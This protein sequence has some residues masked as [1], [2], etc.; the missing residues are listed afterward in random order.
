MFRYYSI[1]EQSPWEM[2]LDTPEALEA[3]IAKQCQMVSV[4]AISDDFNDDSDPDK[5]TY[6]GGL[7]FDIDY[8]KRL[9]KSIEA[10]H[11]LIGKLEGQGVDRQDILVWASGK[12]GFHIVVPSK[13][14]SSGRAIRYLPYIYKEMALELFVDGVDMVVYSGKKGRL[15]RQEN[16]QRADNGKFKVGLLPEEVNNLTVEEYTRLTDKARNIEQLTPCKE[17]TKLSVLFELC[18]KRVIFKQKQQKQDI[19]SEVSDELLSQFSETL[20]GCIQKLVEE[21][22]NEGTSN[23]NQAAMQF[24]IFV[25]RSKMH[26]NFWQPIVEQMAKNVTSGTYKTERNRVEHLIGMIRYAATSSSRKFSRGALFSVISPCGGCPICQTAEGEDI[27]DVD[28]DNLAGITERAD[29][30]Y[31]AT[32]DGARRITT[33]TIKPE[34][35]YTTKAQDTELTRR[36][37]IEAGIMVGG[38]EIASAKIEESAWD[39]KGSLIKELRGIKNLAFLGGDQEVQRLKHYLFTKE[40]DM[41]EI[42]Q[43]F[44]AG[45]HRHPVGKLSTLVYVEPGFSVTAQKERDTHYVDGR[46][47]A[48]PRISEQ[49][50]PDLKDPAFKETIQALLKVNQPHIVGQI[51]GWYAACHLKV[52]LQSVENQFPILNLWGNAESGKTTTA[53]VFACLSGCDYIME[54]SPISLGGATPWAV[55]N[56]AASTTTA[57]RLLDEFNRSKI[58]E[59]NY[60]YFAEVM[61]AAW[62]NQ[63]FSRGAVTSAAKAD[64][65]GRSGAGVI[66]YKISGPI[67]VMSEQSPEMPALKQRMVQV[68]MS[69]KSRVGCDD[70]FYTVLDNRKQLWRLSRAMVWASLDKL[71]NWT[72]KKMKE[73]RDVI[74]KKIE[75]RSNYSYR[76]VL[77]GLDFF[78][79]VLEGLKLDMT[80][81]INELK[82]AVLAHLSGQEQHISRDKGKTEVDAVMQAFNLM[83]GMEDGSSGKTYI[84]SGKHYIMAEGKLYIDLIM[85]HALYKRYAR[86][87]QERVVIS[88]VNQFRTLLHQEGYYLESKK[89]EVLSKARE[90]EVLDMDKMVE[91]GLDIGHFQSEATTV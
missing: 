69:T 16:V 17:A 11:T 31:V 6:K 57:P 4:L 64:G 36:V 30:Y 66:D 65:K 24:G 91:K 52:H 77:T 56:F 87:F 55:A 73:Y 32:A 86:S 45:I 81:E 40:F 22:A 23:F 3:L 49:E 76:V 79:E 35:F 33:Y 62:N 72:S 5:I 18:K 74:P 28:E 20:P 63:T 78:Q 82:G 48:P 13:V 12:K 25:A 50:F 26:R 51:L 75:A 53:C 60:N 61:K 27:Q 88:D 1:A 68:G 37:G 14:F 83:A 10:L 19:E 44:S 70:H 8:D 41:G 21:G 15:W 38:K 34:N 71:P 43:V 29:G 85:A 59:S 89:A 80:A 9:D 42:Q 2:T 54:D 47:P 67:V 39:S 90:M 46:V 58:K 7:Y 84:V